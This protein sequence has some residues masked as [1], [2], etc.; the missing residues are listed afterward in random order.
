MDEGIVI[1]E[2]L[3]MEDIQVDEELFD[4]D[5]DEFEANNANDGDC[6]DLSQD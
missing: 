1:D 2:E 6:D 4:V 5:G 3:F